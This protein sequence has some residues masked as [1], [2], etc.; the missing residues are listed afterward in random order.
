M[1]KVKLRLFVNGET[2][3]SQAAIRSLKSFIENDEQ[4]RYTLEIID[5]LEQPQAAEDQ[6]VLATPTL[7]KELPPPIRRI[8]G[9]LT[10]REKVLV[11][12]D[13]SSYPNS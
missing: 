13:L 9:D 4:R 5:V 8:I 1:N 10:E 7:I 3:T 11:G 2:A 12:L 6:K